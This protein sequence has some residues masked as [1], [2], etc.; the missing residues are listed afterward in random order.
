MY[1][2]TLTVTQS[3]LNAGV[4][5]VRLATAKSDQTNS[6]IAG[7]ASKVASVQGDVLGDILIRP[8]RHAAFSMTYQGKVIYIDPAG[9]TS[10]FSGLPRADYIVITH[11]HSDH[12]E[13]ATIT[14]ISNTN[15][16]DGIPDVKIFAPQA[17]YNAMSATLKSFTTVLDYSATTV[18]PIRST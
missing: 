1:T 18:R 4:D 8:I 12:F 2:S 5:I 14:A 16:N 9:G 17:V 3:Q 10:L 6:Q 13:P 7:T 15:P 11:S